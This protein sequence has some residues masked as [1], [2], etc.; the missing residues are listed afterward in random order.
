M[1]NR[2]HKQSPSRE[3]HLK[4]FLKSEEELPW[5]KQDG[6]NGQRA[7]PPDPGAPRRALLRARPQPMASPEAYPLGYVEDMAEVRTPLGVVF[8]IL[9]TNG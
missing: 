6:Q 5:E 7:H 1:T 8:T 9:M 2:I 4:L 3:D